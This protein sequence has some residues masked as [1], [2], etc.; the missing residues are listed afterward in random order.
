MIDF[1]SRITL[2]KDEFG[3][4][5][6]PHT[7][8]DTAH[9]A[10]MGTL[11]NSG[12]A[13]AADED[14]D[15]NHLIDLIRNDY[16][17]CCRDLLESRDYRRYGDDPGDY[18]NASANVMVWLQKTFG[19]A[20]WHTELSTEMIDELNLWLNCADEDHCI[21]QF[22]IDGPNLKLDELSLDWEQCP[23]LQSFGN[24]P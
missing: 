14:N 17:E 6:L 11:L 16:Y 12:L 5:A 1:S 10:N 19:M 8:I 13:M 15:Y 23:N 7:I 21:H 22:A 2:P 20:M 4:I 24:A 3:R 18:Q 9:P